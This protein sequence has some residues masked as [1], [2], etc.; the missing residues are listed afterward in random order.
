MEVYAAVILRTNNQQKKH[1]EGSQKQIPHMAGVYKGKLALIAE[2]SRNHSAKKPHHF[3]GMRFH[4]FI[5]L[6]RRR[7]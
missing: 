2:N 1:I 4:H 3:I 5:E 6:M 7:S